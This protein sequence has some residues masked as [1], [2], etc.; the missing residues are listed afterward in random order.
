MKK[1]SL[2]QV[3]FLCFTSIRRKGGNDSSGFLNDIT[4]ISIVYANL[5]LFKGICSGGLVFS[6]LNAPAFHKNTPF[7]ETK[8]QPIDFDNESY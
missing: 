1:I 7:I 2:L 3:A 5:Q 6:F 4:L 8:K